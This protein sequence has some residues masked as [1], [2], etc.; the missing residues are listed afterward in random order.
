MLVK[1]NDSVGVVDLSNEGTWMIIS[2]KTVA[3]FLASVALEV[4]V[5]DRHFSTMTQ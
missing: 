4:D 3:L 1:A 5:I 2:V